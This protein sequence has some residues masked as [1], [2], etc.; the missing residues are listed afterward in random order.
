MVTLPEYFVR[1]GDYVTYEVGKVSPETCSENFWNGGRYFH[2]INF[3]PKFPPTVPICPDTPAT[4]TGTPTTRST[5][6]ASQSHRRSGS[7]S[8]TPSWRTRPFR[9][10][11]REPP[12]LPTRASS[13]NRSSWPL[14]S[15]GRRRRSF[16]RRDTS[17]CTQGHRLYK[18]YQSCLA[19]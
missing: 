10:W 4:P 9:S 2:N 8:L 1:A 3:P 14:G 16:T 7:R 18:G 12:S 19:F 17:I 6:S 5:S 15:A 13:S 11:R